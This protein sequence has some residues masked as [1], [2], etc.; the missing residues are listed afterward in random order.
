MF[1]KPLKQTNE[2]PITVPGQGNDIFNRLP[3]ELKL[4]IFCELSASDV[5][6]ISLVC[7]QWNILANDASLWNLFL[8]RDFQRPKTMLPKFLHCTIS[9]LH[10]NLLRGIYATRVIQTE[11]E[12]TH[13]CIIDDG[14]V[15]V[16]LNGDIKLW[17]MEK[18]VCEKIIQLPERI[19]IRDSN[20]LIPTKEKKIITGDLFGSIKILDL[21]KGVCE[22]TLEGHPGTIISYLCLSQEKILISG[23]HEGTIKIWDLEKEVCEKTLEGHPGV[24]ISFLGLTQEGNLISGDWK[25]TIKIWE[26]NAEDCVPRTINKGSQEYALYCLTK[27]KKLAAGDDTGTIKIW[28]LENGKCEKILQRHHHI[29]DS[30][31]LTRDGILVSGSANDGTIK[32]WDLDKG[33]CAVTIKESIQGDLHLTIDGKLLIAERANGEIRVLDFAASDEEVFGELANGFES[34]VSHQRKAIRRFVRMPQGQREKIYGELHKILQASGFRGCARHAFHHRH[35]LTSTPQQRAQAIR[36]Y[37]SPKL[38]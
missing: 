13:S 35:G 28:N 25:G 29:V 10:R 31:F 38:S 23:D 9:H 17:N 8:A 18:G 2:A 26:L 7:R 36:A 14:L 4:A 1:V 30:L 37:L 33:I 21:E 32:I 27:E 16:I 6:S 22:K 12:F 20:C 19:M 11:R 34:D 24:L 15:L 5:L 3:D